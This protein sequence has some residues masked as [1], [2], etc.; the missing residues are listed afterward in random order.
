[1]V[2]TP[3]LLADARYATPTLRARH[4]RELKDALD[5]HF[6]ARDLQH[7]LAAFAGAGVPCAPINGYAEALADP[8]AVHLQLV[9]DQQLPGG[10]ATHTVGSPVRLDGQPIPVDT[11][12][13]ALG[14]GRPQWTPRTSELP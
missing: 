12:V 7:W 1:M 11:T 13:P 8:Q 6:V 9:R 5:P 2:G 3:E 10:R 4:Q 14:S